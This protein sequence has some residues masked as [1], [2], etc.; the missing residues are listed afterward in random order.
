MAYRVEPDRFP[1]VEI[2]PRHRFGD[3][4]IEGV[5]TSAVFELHKAGEPIDLIAEPWQVSQDVIREAIG[6]ENEQRGRARAA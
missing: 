6:F 3:P 5:S 4:Q 2:D 1:G